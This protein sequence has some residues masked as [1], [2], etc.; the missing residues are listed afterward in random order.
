MGTQAVFDIE[1]N[2]FAN[3]STTTHCITIKDVY[4]GISAHWGPD[5]IEEGLYHLGTFDEIIGHN[6]VSYDLPVL[7]QNHNWVFG[8]TVTDTLIMSRLFNPDRPIPFGYKGKGRS[9]SLECWGYRCGLWKKENPNWEVYDNEMKERCDGDVAINLIAYQMLLGEMEG[10]DWKRS[11][12]LEHEV[13]RIIAQQEINGVNFDRG[14]A[15]GL[16]GELDGHITA[17]DDDLLPRLPCKLE[18]PYAGPIKE[19]Y[20]K[21]GGLRSTTQKWIEEAEWNPESIGGP[22]SRITWKDFNLASHPQVKTYLLEHANWQPTEWNFKD[23]KRTSPKLT[24]DSLGSIDGDIGRGIKDRYL[25]CH[26]RSTI[27]GWVSRIRAD[28]RLTAGANPCGTNTG[29]MRHSNVVNVPKPDPDVYL[30]EEMRSLFI[31]TPGRRYVGFD[32]KGIQAR[33]LAH[34]LDVPAFTEKLLVSDIHN[35]NMEIMGLLSRS[36][37]KTVYYALIFGSSDEALG[38]GL[39]WTEE[40]YCKWVDSGE[41]ELARSRLNRKKKTVITEEMLGNECRGYLLKRI[42]FDELPEL[43]QLIKDVKKAAKRG[44]LK[45]LDGR[46]VMMR[47]SNGQTQVHK[48]LNA[49][50]Q[51]AEAVVMKEAM[52]MLDSAVTAHGIDAWKVMDMHDEASWDVAEKDVDKFCELAGESLVQAGISL[53]L[54][55][56]MA[57]DVKVGDHWGMVH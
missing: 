56:P 38:K 52:V 8:G 46:K 21:H 37:A 45:G 33:L 29:R 47:S 26:R 42:Y 32:A 24:E 48:A 51:S 7:L 5:S 11:L 6:I 20:L 34:Y 22:F 14:K 36:P 3:G 31:Q 40:M 18:R 23:G 30:G 16:L 9:H 57:A 17:I 13:A 49:L 53:N 27:N 43:E 28:G 4:T 50:L 39:G 1:T 10:H 19:P 2:G 25:Y 41:V 54:R 12:R 44:W 15:E 55:I 35:V